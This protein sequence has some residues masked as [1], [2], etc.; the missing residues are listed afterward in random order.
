MQPSPGQLVMAWKKGEG[1]PLLVPLQHL[2]GMAEACGDCC[3]PACMAMTSR[4]GR[5]CRLHVQGLDHWQG[6]MGDRAQ[7]SEGTVS[8]GDGQRESERHCRKLGAAGVGG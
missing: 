6:L 3:C 7:L 4:R 1:V 5:T 8:S 2:D